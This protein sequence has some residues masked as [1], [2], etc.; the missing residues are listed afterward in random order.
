MDGEELGE[1]RDKGMR[2]E[3]RWLIIERTGRDEKTLQTPMLEIWPNLADLAGEARR[4][5]ASW[6]AGHAPRCL[7]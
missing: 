7:A 3:E 5:H 4:N 1:E 2:A 6:K